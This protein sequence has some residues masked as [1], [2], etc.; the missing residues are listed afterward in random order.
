MEAW[1]SYATTFNRNLQLLVTN[2]MVFALSN[3]LEGT[4]GIAVPLTN[5]AWAFGTSITLNSWPGWTNQSAQ[6]SFVIPVDTNVTTLPLS[7]YLTRS[8]RLAPVTTNAFDNDYRVPHW[9]LRLTNRVQYIVIDRDVNPNRIIDFV[10]L[11]NLVADVD[12][13]RGMVGETNA[14][15]GG[16]FSDS[17]TRGGPRPGGPMLTVGDMWNPRR[18][19]NGPSVGVQNQIGVAMGQPYAGEGTWRDANGQLGDK[20]AAID[21]FTLFM[22]GQKTNLT[23]QVPFTPSLRLY[24][25]SSWEANDPL[26]HYT[27]EDLTDPATVLSTNLQVRSIPFTFDY[28]K[29]ALLADLN[30]RYRPWGGNPR[31]DPANDPTA[32]A[33]TMKDP[34]VWRSDDW[35]FP[36]NQFANLGWL[37]RVHRGTPWQT[38]YLKSA[39]DAAGK[40]VN[41]KDWGF[42]SGNFGTH[43]TNDWR[44][45]DLF[46]VAPNDNASRG[47]LA[48]NQTN[49]ASWSAVLSGVTA[50][51]N[52]TVDGAVGPSK[53]P[54]YD[55]FV[56]TPNSPQMRYI[57]EGISRTRAQQ[58]NGVFKTL[59]EVLAAPE[60]TVLSPYL[61]N[62]S[63]R[64]LQAGVDDAAY[65]RIPQQILSLLKTDEPR[66]V[67]YAFGQALKPAER[68]LVTVSTV[69][70]PV[71]NLCTNYQVTGEFAA[72]AVLRLEELPPERISKDPL[73]PMA[74]KLRA[75][76]ESYTVLQ[77]D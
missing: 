34:L 19:A 23:W 35:R 47:L 60:L 20:Q 6:T 38:M 50:L 25:R 46:T 58:S 41:V 70:P 39:V 28:H 75:I 3:R 26:V 16:I 33:V 65:E 21:E 74:R 27:V 43:P 15:G 5:T 1:N 77:A 48:V 29:D 2:Q 53:A 10:N 51:T 22:K 62:R 68:S 73:A 42:W 8:G 11:D 59:G 30:P 32:Y 14:G 67:V 37:G 31:K 17:N 24:Q 52:T 7:A 64:Q 76:M 63:A 57:V 44:L 55:P 9:F 45:F 69:S 18:A 40:A 61:N 72:K 49:L 66:V 12:L 71:F 4:A 36:T 13:S 56:I 54:H